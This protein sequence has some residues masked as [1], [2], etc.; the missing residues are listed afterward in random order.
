M[1]RLSCSNTDGLIC[2]STS[3]PKKGQ[4]RKKGLC[5]RVFF[6]MQGGFC[7][8]VVDF[9]VGVFGISFISLYFFL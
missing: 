2:L 7:V 6:L 5:W 4:G 9:G 1:S 3:S 8:L